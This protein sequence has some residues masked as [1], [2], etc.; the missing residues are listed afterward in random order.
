MERSLRYQNPWCSINPGG[1]RGGPIGRL[2]VGWRIRC[3]GGRILGRLVY[4]G[5]EQ[6][7][8]LDVPIYWKVNIE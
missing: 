5:K 2:G 6:L 7:S 1:L 3:R 4:Y 8:V